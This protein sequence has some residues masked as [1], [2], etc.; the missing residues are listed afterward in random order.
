MRRAL[1]SITIACSF[2][3]LATAR[4]TPAFEAARFV[5]ADFAVSGDIVHV[6]GRII[7]NNAAGG[8]PALLCITDRSHA[9]CAPAVVSFAL[10]MSVG[11]VEGKVHYPDGVV[12][13][14]SLTVRAGNDL[15]LKGCPCGGESLAMSGGAH[16]ARIGTP[17]GTLIRTAGGRDVEYGDATGG[18]IGARAVAATGSA[19]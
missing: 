4:A 3:T 8:S 2:M 1:I 10:D 11:G 5:S 14:L 6:E 17:D 7:D 9:R 18:L 12:D 15:A 19:G 13:E 16:V